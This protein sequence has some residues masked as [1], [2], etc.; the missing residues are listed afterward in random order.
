MGAWEW[1]CVIFDE[2]HK[3]STRRA[4]SKAPTRFIEVCLRV[5][6]RAQRVIMLSGCVRCGGGRGL[7]VLDS[8]TNRIDAD[9][10]PT[11]IY[12]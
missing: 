7:E 5:A 1:N 11:Y 8:L 3:L 9:P 12:P 6:Q 10:L 4:T 2:S